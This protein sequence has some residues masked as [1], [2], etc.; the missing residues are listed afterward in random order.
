MQHVLSRVV[1]QLQEF[2]RLSPQAEYRNQEVSG[3]SV[4]QQIEHVLIAMSGMALA[5]RKEHISETQKADNQLKIE[6]LNSGSFPRGVIQA[7]EISRPR[8]FVDQDDLKRLI[9]KTSNRVSGL[10]DLSERS[11][12]DH[13]ILGQ[14]SR[15]E[16]IRFMVIH[17]DHHLS[18]IADIL[19][20]E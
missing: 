8:E 18:I 2:S 6:V 1:D 12:I 13:P 17:N 7:P 3:W 4:G 19:A 15:D 5:L 10:L 11:T 20:E 16:T 14:M 9:L